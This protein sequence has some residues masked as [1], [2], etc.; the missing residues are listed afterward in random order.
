M[1]EWQVLEKKCVVFGHPS[2]GYGIFNGVTRFADRGG[3]KIGIHE[4]RTAL[5]A[6]GISHFIIGKNGGPISKIQD[7]AVSA[8]FFNFISSLSLPSRRQSDTSTEGH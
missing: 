8:A 3:V 6:Q 1:P 2:V 7:F 5:A 4:Q